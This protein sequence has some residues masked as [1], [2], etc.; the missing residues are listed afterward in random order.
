MPWHV[1]LQRK[2]LPL[3]EPPWAASEAGSGWAWPAEFA[4]P[5]A[6]LAA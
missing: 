3:A 5:G 6:W 2:E 1:R 4:E